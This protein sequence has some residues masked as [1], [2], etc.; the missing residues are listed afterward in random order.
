MYQLCVKKNYKS[1]FSFVPKKFLSAGVAAAAAAAIGACHGSA[2][3]GAAAG[4]VFVLR[5]RRQSLRGGGG[6]GLGQEPAVPIEGRSASQ[7]G[8]QV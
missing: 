2:A 5:R 7:R 6:L 8:L 3:A 1:G 4:G